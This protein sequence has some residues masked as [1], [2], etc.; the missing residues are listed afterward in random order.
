VVQ[1]FCIQDNSQ[2]GFSFLHF[3]TLDQ[4]SKPPAGLADPG[5]VEVCR[6]YTCPKLSLQSGRLSHEARGWGTTSAVR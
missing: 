2:L 6:E 1:K 5:Y 3:Q 4:I